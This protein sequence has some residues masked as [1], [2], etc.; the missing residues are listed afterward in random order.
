MT[1]R[2]RRWRQ[3]F[4]AH[5][6]GPR[7][8]RQC[9]SAPR[10]RA[11]SNRRRQCP[12]RSDR[13]RPEPGQPPRG[14][15]SVRARGRGPRFSRDHGGFFW[16]PGVRYRPDH[17]PRRSSSSVRR[18]HSRFRTRWGS[19]PR[20]QARTPLDRSEGSK[21]ARR[22]RAFADRACVWCPEFDWRRRWARR[23]IW[24]WGATEQK[25]HLSGHLLTDVKLNLD[26][27]A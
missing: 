6:S 4:P 11:A 7:P 2:R 24:C 12:L 21:R 8:R 16:H 26:N 13:L 19:V 3:D 20:H 25:T 27:Q 17:H 10:L 18:D 9:R 23:E 14:S 22:L 15:S 1:G 5:L